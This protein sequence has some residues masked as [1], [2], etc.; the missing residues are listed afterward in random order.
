[1]NKEQIHKR[2]SNEQVI[3]ILENYL[4]KEINTREAMTN[5]D[6]ARSQF[7]FWLRDTKKV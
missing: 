2:L 6:L 7:L 3:A 1:M 5:L 4:A